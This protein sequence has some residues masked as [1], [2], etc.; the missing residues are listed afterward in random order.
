MIGNSRAAALVSA[1][2]IGLAATPLSAQLAD[3][4]EAP[5][6][7]LSLPSSSEL[8]GAPA[9]PTR[10]QVP[11]AAAVEDEV[12]V[13]GRRDPLGLP[14]SVR[15]DIWRSQRREMQAMMLERERMSNKVALEGFDALLG[16][17]LRILPTYDPA[18]ERRI[19]YGVNDSA[20]V[21]LI[22]IF[23]GGFGKKNNKASDSQRDY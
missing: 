19:E 6:A 18:N 7:D 13:Y 16:T 3:S 17:S 10:P 12:V 2:V 8:A 14:D 21:G 4:E 23:G 5:A 20:P 15:T 22:N 1:L 9:P 11:F